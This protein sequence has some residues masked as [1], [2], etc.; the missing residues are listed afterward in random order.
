MEADLEYNS[1]V[2][3][4]I[5]CIPF[6]R[7]LSATQTVKT[8]QTLRFLDSITGTLSQALEIRMCWRAS[9]WLWSEACTWQRK[10]KGERG[11][12]RWW[13]WEK[14]NFFTSRTE[15][16]Q[17]LVALGLWRNTCL[18]LWNILLSII[19]FPV[20]QEEQTWF[21]SNKKKWKKGK[22]EEFR[23]QSMHLLKKKKVKL[24]LCWIFK[25][26]QLEPH[27]Y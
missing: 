23:N 16:T 20:L 19:P 4:E 14:R 24:E 10:Q 7:V 9:V 6:I 12:R 15:K 18:D 17:N 11:G 3:V 26:Y 13:E 22:A 1:I 25:S 5:K 27:H 21:Y 2:L 8:T